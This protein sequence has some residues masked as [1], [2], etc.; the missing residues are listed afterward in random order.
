MPWRYLEP[1]EDLRVPPCPDCGGVLL[2]RAVLRGVWACSDCYPVRVFAAIWRAE[3]AVEAIE[4]R[5]G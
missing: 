4:R 3:R 2:V 5:T 1:P